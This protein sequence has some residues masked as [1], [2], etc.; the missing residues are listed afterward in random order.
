[1]EDGK[2]LRHIVD[3]QRDLESPCL[4]SGTL[5][6]ASEPRVHRLVST[7]EQTT[8]CMYVAMAYGSSYVAI[9]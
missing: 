7:A 4:I 8:L 9:Y 5:E 3:Q 2:H 6:D 1:M